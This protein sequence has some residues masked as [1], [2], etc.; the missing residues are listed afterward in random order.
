MD[1]DAMLPVADWDDAGGTLRARAAIRGAATAEALADA[2]AGMPESFCAMAQAEVGAPFLLRAYTDLCDAVT[3]RA[4]ELT[5]GRC[6]P[7][8]V[9]YAWLAFGSVGRGELAL[10][11]DLDNGLAYADTGAAAVPAYFRRF[12]AEVNRSLRRCGFVLDAHGVLATDPDWRMQASDWT[13]MLSACLGRWDNDAVVRAAVAFDVRRVAGDLDVVPLLHEV[14]RQ[15]PRHSRFLMGMAQ[16]GAEVPSPLGFRRRLKGSFDLKQ[17]CLL[18]VQNLARYY[19]CAHGVACAATLA[20]LEAVRETGGRD[21]A[22]AG[23]LRDVYLTLADLQV[24]RQ[25]AAFTAGRPGE[26]PLDCRALC[27]GE[28]AR[29]EEALRVLAAVQERLPRRVSF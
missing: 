27:V 22:V 15:A 4:I 13:A 25:A 28:R 2:A 23:S 9:S 3:S 24:R 14:V 19:A 29:L 5:V 12:A 17:K 6:G 20:R 26:G 16:L 10:F 18:P 11:S 21:A 1:G 7:P 8:P